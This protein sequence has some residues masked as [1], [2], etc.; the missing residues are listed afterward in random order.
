M[1]V[2]LMLCRLM[3]L[4]SCPN[5]GI[6]APSVAL[7]NNLCAENDTRDKVRRFRA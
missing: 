3:S 2:S 5:A 7:L 4:L 1:K 6:V